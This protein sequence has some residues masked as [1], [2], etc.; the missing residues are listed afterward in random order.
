MS[1]STPILATCDTTCNALLQVAEALKHLTDTSQ[2]PDQTVQT[3][4]PVKLPRV[5]VTPST[6]EEY[7]TSTSKPLPRVE[8]ILIEVIQW[9]IVAP[10][11]RMEVTSPPLLQHHQSI[12]HQRQHNYS[13]C[14]QAEIYLLLHHLFNNNRDMHIYNAMRKKQTIDFSIHGGKGKIWK[15]S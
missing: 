4:T 1:S 14:H 6:T 12:H 10:S 13:F 5:E 11:K 8:P 9:A 15:R 2:S 3:P 7:N